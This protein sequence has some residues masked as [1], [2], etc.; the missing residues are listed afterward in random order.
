[1]RHMKA[2]T[3]LS[4]FI[5]FG[6][7]T[8]PVEAKTVTVNCDLGD[9]IGGAIANG[10]P[11]KPVTVN[12]K[13]VCNENVTITQN[14]V[15][16][17]GINP[18][19]SMIIG[20]AEADPFEESPITLLGA[21]LIVIDNLTISDGGSSGIAASSSFF[22][23]SNSEIENNGFDG[24][25]VFAGSV[26]RLN[27]NTIKENSRNGISVTAGFAQII[28]NTI[29]GNDVDGIRVFAGG[30]ALIG[31]TIGGTLGPNFIKG[32]VNGIA[33]IGPGRARIRNNTIGG[34]LDGEGNAEHG[35]FAHLGGSVELTNNTIS[36]SGVYGLFI[37]EGSSGRIEANNTIVSAAADFFV[38]AAVAVYR[39]SSLRIRGGGNTLENT[40][41]RVITS[42]SN[43]AMKKELL[44]LDPLL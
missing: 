37:N 38:G 22:T 31:E 34:I 3:A 9:T 17:Q 35:V 26:A 16:L 29:E 24:I 33:V 40:A 13:G 43:N 20:V 28:D 42:N 32:N 25:A 30:N 21:Q 15:T 10:N 23:V 2:L 1:M 41:P 5:G 39:N 44:E 27:D 14:N 7:V 8:G 19:S 36:G 12:I 11:N 18:A 6:L 4:L